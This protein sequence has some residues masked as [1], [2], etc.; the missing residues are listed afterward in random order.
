MTEF[1]LKVKAGLTVICWSLNGKRE[2][3]KKKEIRRLL[4]RQKER[5]DPYLSTKIIYFK[6]NISSD[7]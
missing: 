1:G 3:R 7:R 6:E 2:E 4:K 5:K